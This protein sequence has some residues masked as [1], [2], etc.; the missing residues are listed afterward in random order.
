MEI[1]GKYYLKSVLLIYFRKPAAKPRPAKPPNRLAVIRW[2]QEE[3][4]P[5]GAGLDLKTNQVT[6]WFHGQYNQR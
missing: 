3:E 1:F 2:F 5:R 6:S 4:E